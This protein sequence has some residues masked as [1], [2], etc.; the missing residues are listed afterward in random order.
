MRAE[1]REGVDT[2]WSGRRA[3]GAPDAPL[4]PLGPVSYLLLQCG[5]HCDADQYVE[6]TQLKGGVQDCNAK[7]GQYLGLR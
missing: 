1:F 3:A 4:E 6:A 5:T 7:H 2:N